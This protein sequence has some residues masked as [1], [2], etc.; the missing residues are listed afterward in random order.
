MSKTLGL[1]WVLSDSVMLR[2]ES[3]TKATRQSSALLCL[4]PVI[5]TAITSSTYPP[6]GLA[7][8]KMSLIQVL[9]GSYRGGRNLSATLLFW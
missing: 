9:L 1:P 4:P 3:S 6:H 8:F 7:L 2:K 5:M